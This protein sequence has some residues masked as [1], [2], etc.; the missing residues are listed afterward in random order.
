[1]K[2][3]SLLWGTRTFPLCTS[4]LGCSSLAVQSATPSPISP[5][6][7]WAVCV[8]T[9]LT[10]AILTSPR[11]TALWAT[12]LTTSVGAW[13]AKFKRP[14][15]TG[16]AQNVLNIPNKMLDWPLCFFKPFQHADCHLLSSG[17]L[18]SLDMHPSPCTRCFIW[19]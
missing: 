17:S 3:P 13:R 8:L 7:Q 14:G 12:S 15:I 16:K 9:F 10:C 4:R 2:A 11:S 19:W 1:M 5:K 6:C 18:S